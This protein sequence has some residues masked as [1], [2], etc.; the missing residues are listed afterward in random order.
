MEMHQQENNAF[1][2]LEQSPYFNGKRE[3]VI[4]KR[5]GV[6]TEIIYTFTSEDSPFEEIAEIIIPIQNDET[7][8][9]WNFISVNEQER[10]NKNK[11][12]IEAQICKVN[13]I[14]IWF[15]QLISKVERLFRRI[16]NLLGLYRIA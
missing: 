6:E 11:D 4:A 13:Q 3:K 10:K 7:L 14:P 8:I 16:S 12:K 2:F 15:M 9:K 5:G 1:A